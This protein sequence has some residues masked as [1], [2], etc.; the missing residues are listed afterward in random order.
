MAT[1]VFCD[2]QRKLDE[3]VTRCE[4]LSAQELV[5]WF[6]GQEFP[7][8]VAVAS[9]FGAESAALLA[10]VAGVDPATPVL[11]LETGVLFDETLGYACHLSGLLGLKDVRWIKPDA[12]QLL[13]DDPENALWIKDPDSCCNL[14]KVLPI[15]RALSGFDAWISGLKRSHGGV[16][17]RVDRIEFEDG[18]FKLNPIADWSSQEVHQFIVDRGLPL[19]P[20]THRGYNSIGCVP[21]TRLTQPGDDPRAGRWARSAKAECGIHSRLYSMTE[22]STKTVATDPRSSI[23]HRSWFLTGVCGTVGGRLLQNVLRLEPSRVVGFD[24]NESELFLL[25]D[26]HRKDAR[27]KF[28][29]GDIRDR[30]EVQT[31]MEGCEFVLH[32]AAMKHVFLCEESPNI[33]VNTNVLG[34]QN[35]IDAAVASGVERLLFTS[36][37]K[38]VNPTNVMGAS[39]LMA[40]RLVSAANARTRRGKQVFAATR[41]GNV[42]GSR[43]SVIPIFARQIRA[44]GPVTLTNADMTRFIMTLDQAVGLVMDSLFL[45]KGGEIFVTKM[46]VAR[47]GD[48]AEVMIEELAESFGH[49]PQDISIEIIGPRAGEKMYEEL[50]NEEESQRAVELPSYFAIR[51]AVLSNF[52]EIDYVYPDMREEQPDLG[53]YNSRNAGAMSKS[54]LREYLRRNPE[55]LLGV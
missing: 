50:M 24:N 39:K 3:L 7:G 4:H 42:L 45:A 19:H 41:F 6:I 44:G 35:V 22:S 11:F 46:P 8:R 23:L 9:S 2:E 25:Y 1:S 13:A 33:A 47:I 30:A 26:E 37:D 48:L 52:R 27:V 31:R 21:C 20:L 53:G 15:A 51:P 18:R 28:Y 14:R 29:T 38:A 12:E 40:E 32:A 43:G 36:S 5:E 10:L 34:T 49:R 17:N 55:L 16:R 54:E